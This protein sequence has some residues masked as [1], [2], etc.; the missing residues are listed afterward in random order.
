MGFWEV[1][2]STTESGR[3]PRKETQ[4]NQKLKWEFGSAVEQY[5]EMCVRYCEW[6]CLDSWEESKKAMDCTGSD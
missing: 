5:Q 1:V 4:Y 6:F 2:C 3:Y